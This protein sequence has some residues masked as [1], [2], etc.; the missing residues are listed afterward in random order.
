MFGK[1]KSQAGLTYIA[2]GT[3]ITGESRFS[4][5][6]LVG[7]EIHGTIQSESSITIEPQGLINGEV[8]CREIKISGYFKGKLQC[9]KLTIT[10]SGTVEGEVA[11]SQMEIFEGGQFIGVRVK[12]QTELLQNPNLVDEQKLQQIMDLDKA[13]V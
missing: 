7:G 10:G 9:E 2:Q 6:A 5:D 12:E 4:G 1:K 13:Q 3:K 11:S 8:V